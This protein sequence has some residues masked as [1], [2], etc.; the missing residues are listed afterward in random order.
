MQS[1]TAMRT[2]LLLPAFI[3]ALVACGNPS[4]F[5]AKNVALERVNEPADS[6]T[7][8]GNGSSEIVRLSGQIHYQQ[9]Q[10]NWE[11]EQITLKGQFRFGKKDLGE[12]E[13][14]GQREGEEIIFIP[15]RED[16]AENVRAKAT[17]ISEDGVCSD[18]F[19]DILVK[20][21]SGKIQHDQFVVQKD[22]V[23]PASTTSTSTTTTTTTSTVKPG[24]SQAPSN[25]TTTSTSTTTTTTTMLVIHDHIEGLKP[26]AFVGISDEE[27]REAFAVKPISKT[28][29]PAQT[30][31]T[32]TTTV[33]TGTSPAPI[34]TTTTSTSTTT[35]TVRKNP[36]VLEQS[37][38]APNNGILENAFDLSSLTQDQNSFFKLVWPE[39]NIHFSTNSLAKAIRE[40]ADFVHTEVPGYNFLVGELS[41]KK[42]G[43]IGHASH[44]NG[45]DADLGYI[46]SH[47]RSAY[48]TLLTNEGQLS[49][50]F[51]PSENW[52][53]MKK[54]FENPEVEVVFV[55]TLIKKSLCAEAIAKGDLKDAKDRGKSFEIL[56]RVRIEDG[57]H[58]H[59]HLRLA[60]QK[61]DKRC[62]NLTGYAALDSGCF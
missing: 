36:V 39:K 46:V 38:G 59:Y 37:V 5:R 23:M 12:V 26:G 56:R 62:R 58:H 17:C 9:L 11:G 29:P 2:I 13:M 55:H 16:L 19:V 45:L 24:T 30:A 7:R 40:I 25:T 60:C 50:D 31:S 47:A 35:T 53:M 32:T 41:K 1:K 6:K 42:G 8:Q 4:Q 27:I 48:V 3:L 18:F 15:T 44:Q 34:D 21:S 14:Q 22:K 10:A 43:L 61:T 20:D 51:M 28:P 57:H 52:A 49:P 54:I 33:K